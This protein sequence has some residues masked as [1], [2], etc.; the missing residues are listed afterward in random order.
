MPLRRITRARRGAAILCAGAGCPHLRLALDLRNF[1]RR[2][3]FAV[4]ATLASLN[5]TPNHHIVLPGVVLRLMLVLVVPQGVLL[6][7]GLLL[8]GIIAAAVRV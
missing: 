2:H 5:V 8:H 1:A 3:R 7:Q 6:L 4:N